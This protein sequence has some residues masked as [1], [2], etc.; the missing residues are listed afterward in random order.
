MSKPQF[1]S[2]LIDYYGD[3]SIGSDLYY[4]L[5]SQCRNYWD[6]FKGVSGIPRDYAIGDLNHIEMERLTN[7]IITDPGKDE[8]D[9][10]LDKY[11]IKR[12]YEFNSK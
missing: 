6:N 1:L 10:Y 3:V 12:V 5:T 8:V 2:F 4:R 7:G 9:R 11:V